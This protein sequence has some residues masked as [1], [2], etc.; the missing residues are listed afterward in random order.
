MSQPITPQ[1]VSL[2][3]LAA[4]SGIRIGQLLHYCRN[5]QIE[6]AH[7][8]RTLWHWRIQTPVRFIIGRKP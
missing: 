3:T 6:G 1:L 2:E 5:G 7:F 4:R 8:D